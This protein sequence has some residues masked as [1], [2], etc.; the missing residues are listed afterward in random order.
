MRL[1]FAHAKWISPSSMQRLSNVMG[2]MKFPGDTVSVEQVAC[3][4]WPVAVGRRIAAKARAVKL[5]RSHLVVEVDDA[6][7]KHQLF[8]LRHQILHK[9][10][11]NI[12]AG[13]VE[14]IEFRVVPAR[15]E[16][17]R[18]RSIA[19]AAAQTDDAEA[20]ADPVL[21]RIYKAAR[22]KKSA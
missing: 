19:T 13:I 12:G 3:A 11:Q 14:D 5:V 22:G 8:A 18:A 17:E 21:R 1:F 2:K 15:R 6:V 10:N 4:A 20:I 7:W 9:M 16:P